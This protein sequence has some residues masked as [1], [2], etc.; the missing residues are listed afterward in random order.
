MDF[1]DSFHRP[2]VRHS[3]RGFGVLGVAIS[4][5]LLAGGANAQ[6]D[7]RSRAAIA[8]VAAIEAAVQG[9]Y[10]SNS[11]YR[12]LDTATLATS[13]ALPDRMI[14]DTQSDELHSPFGGSVSVTSTSPFD[15]YSITMLDVPSEPCVDLLTQDFGR[16]LVEVEAPGIQAARRALSTSEAQ[17]ACSQGD[18]ALRWTFF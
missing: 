17:S 18:R 3:Q 8:Q 11:N 6:D 12:G 13:G 15:T 4:L 10:Q 9:M 2:I 7:N 5:A 1:Q 16:R 14:S